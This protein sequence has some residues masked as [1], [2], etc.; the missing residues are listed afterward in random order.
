MVSTEYLCK[1]YKD[2]FIVNFRFIHL[3]VKF[4]D[5]S[6]SFLKAQHQILISYGTKKTKNIFSL[7]AM[8]V[9]KPAI[10]NIPEKQHLKKKN[11]FSLINALVP[12]FL[13]ANINMPS[14]FSTHK[15]GL[16]MKKM[17]RHSSAYKWLE[18]G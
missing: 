7:V 3:P 1:S 4:R 15:P 10:N 13:I 17:K 11:P 6:I 5:E 8:E 16:K 14:Q 2:D 12:F 18:F 9:G